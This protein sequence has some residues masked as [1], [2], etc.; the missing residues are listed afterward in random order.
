MGMFDR[1]LIKCKC[2]KELEFQSKSGCCFLDNYNESNLPPEVAI[3]MN[4]DIMRYQFCNKNIKLVCD[5]PKKLKVKLVTT[6]KKHDY[7]GNYNPEHPHSK[8][9]ARELE[10]HFKRKKDGEKTTEDN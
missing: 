5:I 6:K 3:G 2:G 1:L 8:K 10:K 4:G 7:E 9:R